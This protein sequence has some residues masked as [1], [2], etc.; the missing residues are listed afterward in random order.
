AERLQT[1]ASIDAALA[2]AEHALL[3]AGFETVDYLSLCDAETL[4]LMNLLDRPARLLVTARLNGV[5][6]LDN[7]AVLPRKK[8]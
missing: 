8:L 1:G 6:L 4:Q 5:R 3:A 2:E 7:L